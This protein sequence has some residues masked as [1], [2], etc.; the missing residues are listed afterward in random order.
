MN[1]MPFDKENLYM[2]LTKMPYSH[3]YT[4]TPTILASKYTRG[5]IKAIFEEAEL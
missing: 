1:Q 3:M 2:N 5:P 4:S